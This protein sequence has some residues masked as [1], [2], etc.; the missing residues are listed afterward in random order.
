M[1]CFSGIA[2]PSAPPKNVSHIREG[3]FLYLIFRDNVL[4]MYSSTKHIS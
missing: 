4:K 1:Y 3:R 2:V